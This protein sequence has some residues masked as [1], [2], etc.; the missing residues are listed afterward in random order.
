MSEESP[1]ISTTQLNGHTVRTV[2]IADTEFVS[3]QDFC[4]YLQRLVSR[5]GDLSHWQAEHL[6]RMNETL[7]VLCDVLARRDPELREALHQAAQ[8]RAHPA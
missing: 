2:R 7:D 4:T 5:I 8:R 3:L 1:T 6:T